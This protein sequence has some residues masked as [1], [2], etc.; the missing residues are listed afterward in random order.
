MW[1]VGQRGFED[2]GYYTEVFDWR[3]VLEVELRIPKCEL[4]FGIEER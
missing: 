3:V 1:V 4:E 2:F